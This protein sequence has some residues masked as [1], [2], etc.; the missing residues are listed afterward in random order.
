MAIALNLSNDITVKQNNHLLNQWPAL[1]LENE[2]HFNQ[3]AGIGAPMQTALDKAGGVYLQKERE[4][5][6]RNLETAFMNMSND[7]NYTLCPAYFTDLIPLGSGYP[8]V[9]EYLQCRWCKLIELGKRA[10]TLIQAGVAVTYSDPNN[11]GVND[12][13]TITINTTVA[14]DEIR[15]YFQ[16]SDGCPTAGDYRYEVEPIHVTDNGA[17]TVTVTAHRALFVSPKQWA[18]EYIAQDPN[19]NKPNVVDT[20]NASTGFVTAVDV[21]RVYTDTTDNIELIGWDGSTVLQTFTGE[22]MD[23]VLSTIRLGNICNLTCWQQAPKMVRVN[24]K[25]G[26]PLINNNIDSEL[27]EACVG[28]ACGNM[29][30]QPTYMANWSLDL[31]R[32][33]HEPMVQTI[34]GNIIPVATNM[35]SKSMYGA[36]YG[37][38]LASDVVF[39]K[40]VMKSHKLTYNLRH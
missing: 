29:M 22:I 18:R 40:R 37:Q 24:Y 30:S 20:D 36:R 32:K 27:Y 3:A 10:Q 26:N 38:V 33:Y 11:V 28:L 2:W 35:Q 6:A 17:G 31:Y 4:Y 39:D 8:T 25:A 12:T 16:V 15:L 34:G 23:D 19:L 21:Y 1:M 7:L 5:I 13:A 9:L 14:N